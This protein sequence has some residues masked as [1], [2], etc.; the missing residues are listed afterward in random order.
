MSTP[1]P[2]DDTVAGI[3]ARVAAWRA[4]GERV[5][6]VPTMGALHA[7]HLALVRTARRSAERVVVSVFVNPTQFAPTE[8]FS[9]YPRDLAGDLSKLASV[10]AD[11]VFAPTTTEMYPQGFA[12]QVS[13]GG[14]AI[15]LETDFR[16][17]FFAGVATVVAKLLIAVGPD[18]AV[19]G[20][21]DFQQFL[22]VRRLVAD[23]RLPVEVVGHPIEREA[24]GLALSSRNAYLSPEERA[25]APEIYAA[26]TEAALAIRSGTDA[27]AALSA[28]RGRLAASGFV[29][30]YVE[31]RNAED[32]S[33]AETPPHGPLRLLA[34]ARLGRTRLIDNIPL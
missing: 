28:A 18:V 27:Q 12:T 7:G 14:P 20:E 3:R 4:A 30:D 22:V 24:D 33:P 31:L 9:A 16:P 25:T 8:D 19:F 2:T 29:V 32:L 17:H 15:G 26:L 34:A 23:L 11:A 6:F 1:P 10:E 21:K 13:V 5:G